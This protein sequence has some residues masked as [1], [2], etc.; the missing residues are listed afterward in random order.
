VITT[1]KEINDDYHDDE[2]SNYSET[3]YTPRNNDGETFKIRND[4]SPLLEKF[5]LDLLSAYKVEEIIRL[6]SG[7]ERTITK[8]KRKK[9]TRPMANKQGVEEIMLYLTHYINNATVQ[10]NFTTGDEYNK[11]MRYISVDITR[12]FITRRAN[13]DVRIDQIDMLIANA[14]NLI[15]IFLTRPLGDGERKSYGES[16]KENTSRNI[17]DKKK[18]NWMEKVAGYIGR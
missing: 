13:W 15:D 8:I 9:N 11:R 5:K 6:E 14:V 17:D 16:F 2:F 1:D 7:E 3:T 12:H 4:P 10:G 18:T